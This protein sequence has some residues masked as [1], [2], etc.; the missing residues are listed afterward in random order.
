MLKPEDV[1]VLDINS[2]FWGVETQVLM[3]N[4]GKAI[5]RFFK[6]KYGSQKNVLVV[7]GPGNNGG[8]GLVAA[9]LLSRENN[10]KVF[11][12]K[13]PKT[14][15]AKVAYN[16]LLMENNIEITIGNMDK[17][18]EI[19]EWADVIIDAVLGVG[20]RGTHVKDPYR[21]VIELIN[22]A[23]KD[24]ISVDYPSGIPEDIIVHPTYVITF[25]DLKEGLLNIAERIRIADIGI[26]KEAE[27]Y[28][29]PGDIY[30]YYPK[31]EKNVHKG[32]RG[33]IMVID[34]ATFIGAIVLSAMS[35]YRI[36]V[37]LVYVY[38]YFN[39]EKPLRKIGYVS[40]SPSIVVVDD[41]EMFYGR[42][43][44]VLIGP[45]MDREIGVFDVIRPLVD[46]ISENKNIPIILDAGGLT[47]LKEY[48]DELSGADIIITPHAGEFRY[49]FERDP[50]RTLSERIENAKRVAKDW[51]VTIVLKGPVDVITDGKRVKLNTTGCPSMAVGGSGDVLSGVITGLRAKVKDSFKAAY[52]GAFITGLAGEYA[53]EKLGYGITP[54]DIIREV[55]KVLKLCLENPTSLTYSP[56]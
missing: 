9:R 53:S 43:D 13:E 17:L 31:P 46:V 30:V 7:C 52:M 22:K 45:G 16:K 14:T 1:R 47:L 3:E 28:A 15:E 21:S 40:Y 42:S 2:C 32:Q 4:A 41:L 25:H 23:G 29:G 5:Y 34:A 36:G 49:L 12:L 39:S 37:D 51:E 50:G 6:E 18:K 26:P 11:L 38:T 44:A 24:V 8:D 54:E 48:R 20:V 27:I 10:V 56:R 55:P 35:A 19:I 33:R